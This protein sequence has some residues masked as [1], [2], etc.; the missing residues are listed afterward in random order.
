V[1]A[2]CALGAALRFYGIGRQAFWFDEGNTVLLIHLSLGKML[3]LIPQTESTPPVYYCLA[4][5][6]ARVFGFGAAGLRSLSAL[7]GVLVIPVAYGIGVKLMSRRA[8]LIL[9]A[10]CACNPFLIWYSQEARSYELLVLMCALAM[11][12]FVYALERPT[13]R[14]LAAWAA[15]SVLALGTH[16]YALVAIAP[17][18]AWLVLRRG[19]ERS[20]R[21]SVAAVLAGGAALLPLALTQNS[22]G[23][24]S[25]IGH[26]P[27][28]LRLAQI[29]PQLVIGTDAPARTA[30]KIAGLTLAAVGLALLVAAR[31]GPER[32]AALLGGGLALAGFIL[33]LVFLAVG[34]DTLITRNIIDLWLPGAVA[35]AGGLA[36]ARPPAVGVAVAGALCAIGVTAAVGVATTYDFQRPDWRR[37]AIALG[38]PPGPGSERLILI[39]H[40]RTL[41]PLSLYTPHL[42]FLGTRTA[43]HVV[44][45]DVVAMSSP[46]Q[47][48]CWW[49]AACNLIPSRLQARYDIPGFRVLWRRRVR[50]FTLMRLVASQPETVTPGMVARA[51]RT[52]T[53]KRDDLLVQR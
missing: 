53:L 8:G 48:L 21:I 23:R 41:L 33:A 6:W 25:W 11:L 32:R 15:S 1:A 26:S 49:G 24:D 16:Y 22:T 35:L 38:P 12:A 30:L 28:G 31:H 19:R 13:G 47:P 5:A 9:A 52:T 20:V 3:G 4:W 40:Y 42:R 27:L 51:L 17:Q 10:L 45:L 7:T 18:V 34:S 44:E 2:L 14:W 46:Q 36:L 37:V 39:Q 50:R 43:H 29:L